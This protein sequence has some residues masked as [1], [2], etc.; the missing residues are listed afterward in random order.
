MQAGKILIK[1]KYTCK[2]KNTKNNLGRK[3]GLHVS[4]TV[5]EGKTG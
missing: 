4:I 5:T 2:I 3:F 1:F